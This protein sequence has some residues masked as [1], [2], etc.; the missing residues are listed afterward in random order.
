[1]T[2]L[3]YRV[4]KFFHCLSFLAVLHAW[5]AGFAADKDRTPQPGAPLQIVCAPDRPLVHTTESVT[6]RA[7][8]TDA[9]G[10][11]VVQA[12][13]FTWS[14]STGTI[15]GGEEVTW[16][17][18]QAA[19]ES[20]GVIKASAKVTARHEV[21]GQAA[22]ELLVYVAKP[23][24]SPPGP[25]R[26]GRLSAR[27]FLLPDNSK[28]DGYGLYSYL[29][30]DTP[31]KNDQERERHLKAIEAYLLV[32]QPIEEMERH[33]RRSELNIILLPLKRNIELP[34]NLSDPEQAAQAARQVLAVY[35]YARAKVLLSD[36]GGKA[37]SSGPYLVSKIS[38]DTGDKAALLFFDM[39]HVVPKL[40]WDWVKAFCSLA[41]QERS[42]TDVTLTKLA[43]NTRNVIAVGARDTPQVVSGLEK[44]IKEAKPR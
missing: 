16:S 4:R 9:S 37:V 15:S 41:A 3:E 25:D 28:P 27:A 18:G 21:L 29:L 43:L 39:S 22:C 1:M 33:R 36:L 10:N 2:R 17:F 38:A 13:Q 11:P 30:F 35:H 32:L 14:A 26:S 44:W 42:W 24:A 5:T 7:W 6:L 12:V 31:P 40:V 34:D 20:G 23:D 19:E 8:V